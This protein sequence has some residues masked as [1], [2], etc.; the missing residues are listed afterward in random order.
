MKPLVISISLALIVAAI[1]WATAPLGSDAGEG[2]EPRGPVWA[3]G[4]V[5][6]SASPAARTSRAARTRHT[7]PPSRL[8][9]L[10][11]TALRRCESG[12]NYKA[13]TGN[14]FYG[15]YQFDLNT[16]RS[17]G[18]TGNPAHASKEEQDHRARL[19]YVSR[20]AQPWP[21]CGRYLR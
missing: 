8:D 17:V 10:D 7:E 18:G 19:L 13:D 1:G 3:A 5:A 21:S 9:L 20:G 11:W 2:V 12:G 14:G 16:W 15:A 6:S 4:E